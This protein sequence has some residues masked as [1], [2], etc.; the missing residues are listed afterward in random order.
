MRSTAVHVHGAEEEIFYVLSGSGL[1]WQGGKSCE[2][3]EGDCIAHLAR[4]DAHTLRSGDGGLD[5]LA[6]GTRVPVGV[7]A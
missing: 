4:T 1:L 6:F 2:V 7:A 5:V 3:R